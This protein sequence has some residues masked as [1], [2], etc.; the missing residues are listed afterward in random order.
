MSEVE[1]LQKKIRSFAELRAWGVFHTPKNLSM[2][3]AAEAGELLAE[4]QWLTPDESALEGLSLAQKNAIEM[5]I[6]DILIYLVRL[7]DVLH[8]DLIQAAQTKLVIN[9]DRFPLIS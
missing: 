1:D 5:E 7:C 3:L 2:A 6:A 4:F 9:E 8:V